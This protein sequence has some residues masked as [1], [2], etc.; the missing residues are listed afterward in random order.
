[1]EHTGERRAGDTWMVVE[2][3]G[4]DELAKEES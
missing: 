4:Q 3:A 2:A 1:M